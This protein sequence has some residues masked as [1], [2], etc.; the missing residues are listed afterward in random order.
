MYMCTLKCE[1]ISV[2]TLNVL[3]L[4]NYFPVLHRCFN[5]KLHI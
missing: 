1:F 4:V 5:F 2:D 3:V